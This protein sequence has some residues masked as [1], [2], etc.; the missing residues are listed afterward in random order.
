MSLTSAAVAV[1]TMPSRY[2]P[3]VHRPREL[4]RRVVVP[5]RLRG[6]DTGWGDAC[7]LNISSGGL[8]VRAAKPLAEGSLV[9]IHRDD[10]VIHARVVWR[11][12]SRAG[13]QAEASV[14]IENIISLQ[15]P[16]VRLTALAGSFDRRAEP[17]RVDRSRMAGRMMEFVGAIAIGASL[18]AA[19]LS[20]VEQAFARPLAFVS[21]ALGG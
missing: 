21:A 14:P 2:S 12:G 10:H 3:R 13:L 18:A 9:E 1:A 17:R 6:P 15:P 8:L 4:R 11:E 20:M 5:A 19:S 7:I 16:E